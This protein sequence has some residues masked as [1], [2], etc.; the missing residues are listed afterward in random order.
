VERLRSK[1][2]GYLYSEKDKEGKESKNP[3]TIGSMRG[4]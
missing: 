3:G 4:V 1:E 2:K